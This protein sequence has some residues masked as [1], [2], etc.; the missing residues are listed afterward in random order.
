ME[1]RSFEGFQFKR[2]VSLPE[3]KPKLNMIMLVQ[4]TG[5]FC[6]EIWDLDLQYYDW[7]ITEIADIR[8][9]ERRQYVCF[10]R[11][12]IN[13]TIYGVIWHVY[14]IQLNIHEPMAG[15]FSR[16]HQPVDQSLAV[17]GQTAG[18]GSA[19]WRAAWWKTVMHRNA[20][21]WLGMFFFQDHSR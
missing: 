1:N 5:W 21:A 15:P 14:H 7:F 8:C 17:S 10:T 3:G 16:N 19:V 6:S 9:F 2:Y 18:V 4:Q 12:H 13:F 20:P 11:Y